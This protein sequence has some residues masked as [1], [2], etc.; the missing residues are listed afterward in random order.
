MNSDKKI[1]GVRIPVINR[2]ETKPIKNIS[3]TN[4][5]D[6]CCISYVNKTKNDIERNPANIEGDFN[7]PVIRFIFRN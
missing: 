6:L 1:N 7:V 3:L 4:V 2:M 5:I